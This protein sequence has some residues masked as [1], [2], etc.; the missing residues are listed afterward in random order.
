MGAGTRGGHR[1]RAAARLPHV[2]DGPRAPAAGAAGSGRRIPPHP[3]VPADPGGRV[4]ERRGAIGRPDASGGRVGALV[5]CLLRSEGLPTF[6]HTGRA[7][8]PPRAA[9]VWL[10]A[11]RARGRGPSAPRCLRPVRMAAAHAVLGRSGRTARYLVRRNRDT[12]SESGQPRLPAPTRP[13]VSRA[14]TPP[15]ATGRP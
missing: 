4:Q 12:P 11:E 3:L 7:G 15:P 5:G 1:Q 9:T 13:S 14:A 8:P 10:R 6:E 2:H